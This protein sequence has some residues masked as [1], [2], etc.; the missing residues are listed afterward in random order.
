[1]LAL[2]DEE[3]ADR[4]MPCVRSTKTKTNSNSSF[5]APPG[6]AAARQCDVLVRS[7]SG[8][9]RQPNRLGSR[10]ITNVH[11][12]QASAR[13]KGPILEPARMTFWGRYAERSAPAAVEDAVPKRFGQLGL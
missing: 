2:L 11:R 12:H 3:V 13:A 9:D 5:S 8:G 1:V 4:P 6:I 7:S 10:R